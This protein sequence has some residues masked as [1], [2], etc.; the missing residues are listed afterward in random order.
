MGVLLIA[1]HHNWGLTRRGDWRRTEYELSDTG[2]LHI[3]MIYDIPRLDCHVQI[4]EKDLSDIKEAISQYAPETDEMV[5][6]CDGCAWS[7]KAFD[8]NGN[9]LFNR[10][11]G[12][13]GSGTLEVIAD[14]LW[15]DTPDWPNS[16]NPEEPEIDSAGWSKSW[17]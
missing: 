6:M 11:V 5:D 14:V 3:V 2:D 1:E 9:I 10:D 16:I 17:Q 4:S 15:N 12:Y 8:E 7:C 13:V